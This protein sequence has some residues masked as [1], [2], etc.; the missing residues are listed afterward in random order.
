[1]AGIFEKQKQR[2][3]TR[4]ITKV[5]LAIYI[6]L[7]HIQETSKFSLALGLQAPL[8]LAM[9]SAWAYLSW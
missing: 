3:Q 7:S 5:I 8:L 2:L 9:V 1:M 4:K 6:F